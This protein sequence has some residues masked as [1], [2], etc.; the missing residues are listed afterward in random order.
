MAMENINIRMVTISKVLSI[1]YLGT[2]KSLFQETILRIRKEVLENIIFTREEFYVHSSIHCLAKYLRFNC[3][4]ELF[5]L[6]NKK[7][8]LDKVQE[9]RPM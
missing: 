3:L 5:I 9:K 8:G 6:E 2:N 4:M 7:M 1:N